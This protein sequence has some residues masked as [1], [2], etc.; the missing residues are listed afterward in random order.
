MPGKEEDDFAA[1]YQCKFAI[2]AN[3]SW[4]YFPLKMSSNE[5][6]V[7][8]PMHFARFGNDFNRWASVANIYHDWIYQDVDGV[9]HEYDQCIDI[10]TKTE[11]YYEH[12]FEVRTSRVAVNR[13]LQR[14]I[15]KSINVT[16]L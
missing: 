2:I 7:I 12:N 16:N 13:K 9:L 5:P 3:S 11:Q 14:F 6:V 15:P 4:G 10:A 8:A 1:L